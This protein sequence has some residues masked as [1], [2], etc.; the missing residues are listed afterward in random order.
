MTLDEKFNTVIALAQFAAKTSEVFL[1][2]PGTVGR[3]Y[4]G[5]QAFVGLMFSF[6]WIACTEPILAV[7]YFY[8]TFGM[9]VV[10]AIA[11]RWRDPY[12]H[13]MYTGLPWLTLVLRVNEPD[14][15]GAYEVLL[16]VISGTVIWG[17]GHPGLGTWMLTSG[18]GLALSSA[19]IVTRDKA[20]QQAR[21]DA[22]VEAGNMQQRWQ[23][24]NAPSQR[25]SGLRVALVLITLAG[26]GWLLC[27][28]GGRL[29]EALTAALPKFL[30]A[31]AQPSEEERERRNQDREMRQWEVDM[32]AAQARENAQRTFWRAR[33]QAYGGF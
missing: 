28:G 29:P 17:A 26:G 20:A 21:I 6:L 2:V 11:G 23:T 25:R 15:K 14:A 19:Y 27:T 16:V 31:W 5:F 12:E 1:R 22:L 33:N 24:Y 8:A 32:R 4:F 30:P 9:F 18:V 7:F 13:S 3:R 10:H